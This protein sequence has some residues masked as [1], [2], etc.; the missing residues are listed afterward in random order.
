M[1]ISIQI[2]ENAGLAIVA[3]SG[4]FQTVDARQ[5]AEALWQ[6]TAWEGEAAVWDF[7][8][9]R[10]DAT[11]TQVRA[12]AEFILT[13][14]RQ[15][16]PEKMAFVTQ[17]DVEYGL[18]RMFETYREDPRTAFRVFRD[19]EEAVKWVQSPAALESHDHARPSAGG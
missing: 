8:E 14:Q 3:C 16:P 12:F 6:S 13:H 7:R 19:Y 5:A 1:P 15:P 17:R 9:A 18:A 11:A 2:N 10:I 4:V